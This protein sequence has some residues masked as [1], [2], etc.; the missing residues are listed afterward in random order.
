MRFLAPILTF[1]GLH[2]SLATF[3][4]NLISVAGTTFLTMPLF[5]RCFGWW[6]FTEKKTPFWITPAGLG[7]LG[8][9]FA[10]EVGALWFLLPW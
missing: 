3:I 5:I 9:L 7:F 4:S 8:A 1:F 10:I 2:A 6:L